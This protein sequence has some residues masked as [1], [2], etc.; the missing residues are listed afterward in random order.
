MQN[1][2]MVW[3]IDPLPGGDASNMLADNNRRT[4]FSVVRAVVVATQRC[5]KHTSTATSPEATMEELCFLRGPCREGISETRF[6]A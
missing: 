2:K 5:G 4:V 1:N 6:G 3:R